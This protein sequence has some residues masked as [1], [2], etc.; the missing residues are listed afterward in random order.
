MTTNDKDSWIDLR[1]IGGLRRFA[2][3]ITVFNILGHTVFGFEQSWAQPLV[4]LAAAYCCELFCEWM[5][6][7]KEVRR[8]RFLGSA[9]AFLDFLLPA[10]IT[11]LAVA[12]LLYASD[13]LPPIVLAHA[14]IESR[15]AC[16][17]FPES[18]QFRNHDHFAAPPLGRYS[19]TVS[20]Q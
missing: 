17:P 20:L 1:R 13:H 8:P 9:Q 15:R 7:R 5:E 12:M 10:H 19:T 3:A 14:S 11:G 2:V 6:A 16:A 4:S 18:F